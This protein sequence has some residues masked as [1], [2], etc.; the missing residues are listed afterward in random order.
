MTAAFNALICLAVIA[1]WTAPVSAQIPGHSAANPSL[2]PTR[3]VARPRHA[4]PPAR[5][6]AKALIISPRTAPLSRAKPAPMFDVPA[7][8]EWSDDQGFSLTAT[9]LAYKGRF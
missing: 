7:K 9:R 4:S 3:T 6:P 5:A 1:A 2:A 8:A